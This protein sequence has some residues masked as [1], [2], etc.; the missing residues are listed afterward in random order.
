[1]ILPNRKQAEIDQKWLRVAECIA[2]EF[3]RCKKRKCGAIIVGIY[4]NI[5]GTGYNFHPKKTCL[6][7]I[8]LREEVKSG[9][10]NDIGYCC[11]AEVNAATHANYNDMQRATMYVTHAPC[12]QCARYIL[13][14]GIAR[15]VYYIDDQDRIDGIRLIKD[16]TADCGPMRFT[17]SSYKRQE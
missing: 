3:S 9:S 11:H 8:C 10:N 14:S 1:M 13:N 12:I 4:G 5:V 2:N 17:M 6:D 7:H 15:L 16:L